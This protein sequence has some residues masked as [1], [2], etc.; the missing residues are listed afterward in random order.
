MVVLL[1]LLVVTLDFSRSRAVS[2]AARICPSQAISDVP[3]YRFTTGHVCAVLDC[4]KWL[5]TPSLH[6]G[7]LASNVNMSMSPQRQAQTY[8]A[9]RRLFNWAM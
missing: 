7:G 6:G 3:G 2:S 5:L 1:E 4:R 8:E 9:R